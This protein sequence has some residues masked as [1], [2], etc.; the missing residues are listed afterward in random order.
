MHPKKKSPSRINIVIPDAAPAEVSGVA[1]PL[2]P[3]DIEIARSSS[4]LD[5]GT[6]HA[7]SPDEDLAAIFATVKTMTGHDF[8]SYKSNTIMRR[9]ER[10]M[11]ENEAERLSD[12]R[13]F[14]DA[15]QQEAHALAQE[16][17]ISVTGFFRDPEAFELLARDIIPGLFSGRDTTDPVRIWHAGC[18]TGEEVYSMAMLIQEYLDEQEITVRVQIFATD[19][20]ESAIIQ[21][22]SGLYP[23]EIGASVEEK[24]LKRFFMKTGAGWQVTKQ[25]R[26]MVV[27]AHHN[28]I[29]DPPF[30]R[31]DLLVCRNFLIYLNSDIQKR[32]IPLFHQMLKPGGF[33]FLGSAE[34]VGRHNDLFTP[35]NKKWKIF[36]RQEGE[37]PT[38]TLFP[39]ITPVIKFAGAKRSLT[40]YE[41]Q[42]QEPASLAEML[43]LERYL[44]AR[45]I[46]NEQYEVVHYSSRTGAYLETPPGV[47]THDLMK[48]A[49]ENL[50]PS[51]RAAIYKAFAEQQ[52]VVFRGIKVEVNDAE[53]TVNIIVTPLDAP[54][55]AVKLALVIF[56]AVSPAAPC[57]V[58]GATDERHGEEASRDSLVRQLEEQLRVTYEQLQA[59]SEQLETSNEGFMSANEEMMSVNEELQSTNEELHSTNEELET[60][61]E[62]LQALNEELLTVNAELLER[63]AEL[64]ESRKENEFLANI[65]SISAQPFGVGYPDGRLGL[66]NDAFEQLT[67]YSGDELR[68]L[69]WANTLTP[70][71]W[72]EI[73]QE[74]L[75]ELTRTGQPVRYEKEYVRKDGS[76]VPMELLVHL[77][78][79]SAGEPE[80]FYSFLTDITERKQAE[81]KLRASEERHRLLA[82]TMLQGVVHQS[83]DGMIVAM[84]PAAERILGKTREELLGNSSVQ[85]ERDCIRENGEI[86][87]G[88]EHPA[89]IALQTGQQVRQVVM[90]VYNPKMG[91][92][93][94][95]NIDA[96]PVF[97][98]G[99]TLPSEVYTVFEDISERKL[100]EEALRESEQRFRLATETSGVGI[101]EWNVITNR[102]FWDS[103]MFRIY[104]ITPTAD[105][106]INYSDWSTTVL[107]EDL[108]EQESILNETARQ[109]GQSSREFRLRRRDNGECR[110]IQAVETVRTNAQGQ[111]EWVV[112]TNLDVTERKQSEKTRAA[113][114]AIVESTEDAVIGKDLD[115]TITS[116]NLGAEQLFGYRADEMIGQSITRIIPS[117][118]QD[119]ESDILDKLYQGQ[120]VTHF[121]TERLAKDG[122]P[123]PISLTVSPIRDDSG[124]IIGASKIARDISERKQAEDALRRYELLARHSRDIILFMAFDSGQI[125]EINAAAVTA[126]G[127]TREE[128]LEKTINDLRAHDTCDVT[129]TQMAESACRGIQFETVHRRKDGSTFPVEVSSQGAVIGQTQTLISVVRDIT[130]RKQA[131]EALRQQEERLRL[132][133]EAAKMA[134]WDWHVP[135]GAVIWNDMHFRMMGYEPG[136]VQPSY[137]AWANRVHPD[138]VESV[139]KRIQECMAGQ[140]VYTTEF[141]T[142]WP[143]GTVRWLEARGDTEYS[144]NNEPQ[145]QYGVMLDITERKQAEE[146]L[147]ENEQ[148]FRVLIQN[149][150]SAVALINERG[151]FAI[152]NQ[153]FLRIFELNDGSS[154]LNVNERDWSKWEVFDEDSSLLDV[155]EHP[156]RKAALTGTPVRDKLIAVKAPESPE[157]K[158]LLVS[159]EPTVDAQGQIH[160]LICTYHDITERK[161]AEEQIQ[162]HVEELRAL[163]TDLSRFNKSAVGRELRMVELKKEINELCG[164]IGQP[165]RYPLEFEKGNALK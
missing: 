141:R 123:I 125:L 27:F 50:R 95:I 140:I 31:L 89:M 126:Y 61:K 45:V 114:A 139:L 137:Q 11:A 130:G 39:F 103:Q 37:R 112:G 79:N 108:P 10:R 127:Y 72:R 73:E 41:N 159:V 48:L 2:V 154:I 69:D 29:R 81:E 14:I 33:L 148:Q 7:A 151:E 117:E 53:T 21:A 13:A 75:E 155:D 36:S 101:W 44:P 107:P 138:D 94:W 111:I 9:I 49:K 128:L 93:R 66:I 129:A 59:T 150:K 104:G 83:A 8:S 64:Q 42:Q 78:M 98:S 15:N 92:Y 28:L 158:W 156:V 132:A 105:G 86:F 56:E 47:P 90:G 143:D 161:Q 162:R 133:L 1:V 121:E 52:E 30:S 97:R 17:L 163:N 165:L 157:L 88:R 102:I 106:H 62:E 77:V 149:L 99:D 109:G 34:T 87:P 12:Y 80:Y 32:L 164:Q 58:P 115:G 131:E 116:W 122:R 146:V 20:D 160:R 74:K 57:A 142:R 124:V 54:P 100:A 119:E 4:L 84:N 118:L 144:A 152:V 5:H 25:L 22:R 6:N 43:L 26:E 120:P 70:P 147:R 63:M 18:A 46:V 68:K 113:L 85:V 145:R 82:D 91:E 134:A 24:R 135:S 35:V 3:I 110:Y 65:L 55:P 51:L 96:V 76:R 153:A 67:G 136:E 40:P 60:S 23:Y 71:E 19:I 16:I 38:D